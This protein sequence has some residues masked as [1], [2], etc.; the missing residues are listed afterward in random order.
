MTEFNDIEHK[1]I[2]EA[3]EEVLKVYLTANPEGNETLVREAFHFSNQAHMG[4]R[5]KSGE[6]Y[7]FHPIAVAMI[8]AKEIGLGATSIACAF[9]HDVVEDTEYTVDDIEGLFGAKI[10]GIVDGLTKLKGATNVNTESLQA[11]YFKKLLLTMSEDIRVIL[12]KIADRLHNMRTLDAMAAHKQYK[13]ASETLYI[14]APLSHRLGLHLIKKELE[15][16][17]FKFDH[18]E[19][20]KI[21]ES[22]LEESE[23]ERMLF[24]DKFSEPIKERLTLL[25]FDFSI[26]ERVKSV[27]SIWQKMQ[28]KKVPFE[29]IYDIFAIR[30]VFEPKLY[31]NE[32][33]QCWN[34]YSAITDIYTPKPD[35]IRDWLSSPKANGYEAL[36]G[37]VMGPKGKWVEIQIRSKRMNEVAEKGYAAHWKYKGGHELSE[38]ALERW[39]KNVREV[40]ESPDSDAVEFLD[41]FKANLFSNEIMVFTP[42]GDMKIMAQESTTLDFAFEIHSEVGYHCIGAKVNHKTVPLSYK[43]KSGDQVE[44]LTSP[45]AK[46]SEEWIEY[47][48]SGKAKSKIKDL[49]KADRK[50]HIRGGEKIIQEELSKLKLTL[51][52][53]ILK[54]LLAYFDL[55]KRDELYYLIGKEK[56]KVDGLS[57]ILKEKT[58]NKLVKYWTLQFWGGNKKEEQKKP[59]TGKKDVKVRITDDSEDISYH[60]AHCCHP[61]PGDDV[62]GFRNDDNSIDLHKRDCSEAIKLMSSYGGS[63]VEAEWSTHKL[64][65]FLSVIKI[66]GIDRLGMLNDI[67]N[68]ISNEHAVNMRTV[69][70]ETYDGIFEGIIHL[71]VPNTEELNNLILKLLKIRGINSVQR[72]ENKEAKAQNKKD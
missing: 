67:S 57:K 8:I 22:K 53:R 29:E 40:L 59:K 21:I 42:K 13:I 7:I 39:L 9:L 17:S 36:H 31:M 3:F 63:I 27:Y 24:F 33:T 44:I 51:N 48:T 60:I 10:A 52:T 12:I 54:K 2:S 55:Q 11:E 64:M 20:Y 18:P 56:I 14:Y 69:H 38:T 43:L 28:L 1:Q 62:V 45:K 41:D 70:F 58:P 66:N 6:P 26:T 49:F 61:I 16:L 30:L 4:M 35:R 68:L 15:D 5:R 32:K 72:I 23:K 34:I 19:T 71:Y 50:K 37:T 65:S 46:P 25:D 47:V